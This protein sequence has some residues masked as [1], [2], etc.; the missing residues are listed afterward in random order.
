MLYAKS[1]YAHSK[2][3]ESRKRCCVIF[4]GPQF[5]NNIACLSMFI[6][7]ICCIEHTMSHD[8]GLSNLIAHLKR[9][10]KDDVGR[11]VLS[12]WGLLKQNVR[13]EIVYPFSDEEKSM[14]KPLKRTDPRVC[15]LEVIKE[16][17]NGNTIPLEEK[18]KRSRSLRD[19][20]C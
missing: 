3:Q 5:E 9:A 2:L 4:G 11:K 20:Y 6:C 18:K 17:Q 12:R 13:M 8:G 7:P 19:F 15:D 16:L 10:H 1:G 14:L